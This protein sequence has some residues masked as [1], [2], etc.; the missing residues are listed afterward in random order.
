MAHPSFGGAALPPLDHGF[1]LLYNLD[2]AAAHA[3]FADWER[4]HPDDPI[5]PTAD[6]AGLL[7]SQFE[8]LG[9]LESQ[10]F[11]NDR[12]FENRPRLSPDPAARERFS[13]A[14]DRAERLAGARL[15]KNPQDRDALF[16]LALSNGLEADYAA[17]IEKRNLASLRYTKQS[18]IWAEKTLAVDP[19]CYDAHIA[20]GISKY[21]IG[22]MALPVRWLVH[23]GGI[24]GD[25]QQGIQELTLV[26]ERGHYLR[27][28]AD[29]LLAI[30]YVREHDKPRARQL[31]GG[32]RDQFPANPLFAREIATLD[33]G[34]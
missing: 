34:R 4:N 30:A 33:A 20:S 5:A 8:R 19:G 16:A 15:A 18:T 17:L 29:I 31:L 3:I 22:S 32:L 12:E 13:L 10:F 27:P 14:L 2:F 6:A 25:R 24:S 21:L 28:F 7:F 11:V 1:Q 9:V 26:S 23:L